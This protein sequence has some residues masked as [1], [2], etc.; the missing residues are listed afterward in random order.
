MLLL[1]AIELK[2]AHTYNMMWQLCSTLLTKLKYLAA[3]FDC[4]R[5]KINIKRIQAEI[6]S[7]QAYSLSLSLS[8]SQNEK[9]QTT[10]KNIFSEQK[11]C[12]ETIGESSFNL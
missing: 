4:F 1:I 8:L 11:C 6:V 10:Y 5:T 9:R 2:K 7:K 12:S 3:Q